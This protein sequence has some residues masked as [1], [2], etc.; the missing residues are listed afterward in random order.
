M[1][2]QVLT[3]DKE[4]NKKLAALKSTKAKQ[5]VRKASRAALRPVHADAKANAPKR[6]GKL[7]K[8]IKLRALKRS[9]SRI[10]AQVT[11]NVVHGAPQE[12]GWKVGRRTRNTDI[13]LARGAKRDAA[14]KAEAAKRDGSRREIRGKK[15]ME[16]A[17]KSKQSKALAIYRRETAHWIRQL[18]E[19]K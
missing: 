17:A 1:T 11:S 16:R 19:A 18:S 15:F 3:G 2:Q 8:G 13:G 5:A 14:A 10:G 6:S 9:R 12:Y 7:R 4:L